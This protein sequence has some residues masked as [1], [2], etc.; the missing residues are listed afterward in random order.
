MRQPTILIVDD[1]PSARETLRIHLQ[2][3]PYTLLFA[4]SAAQAIRIAAE[5]EIDT[6]LLDVMMPD[7]TGYDLCRIWRQQERIRHTPI[8]LIT[9]L[10]GK[11]HVVHGLDAGADDFLTK[12]FNGLELRARVR[13]MLRIKR[14]YDEMKS[15][16]RMREEVAMM[17]VHDMRSPL[18]AIQSHCAILRRTVPLP[19][20]DRSNEVIRAQTERLK[21]FMNEL[22]LIAKMEHDHFAIQRVPCDVQKIVASVVNT[23]ALIAADSGVDVVLQPSGDPSLVEVDPALF[24]RMIENLVSNAVKFS[25]RGSVV[26]VRVATSDESLLVEVEDNGRGIPAADRDRVFEKFATA[27]ERRTQQI[28][29]GLAFCRAV[30]EA[31]GGQISISD[32]A[33]RG[34]IFSVA[35][36]TPA[37]IRGSLLAS[38]SS[39]SPSA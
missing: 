5:Q 29:L 28:G 36:Q 14:Q 27:G 11:Q 10:D 37:S 25:P 20:V 30:V 15:L 2:Q 39:P 6:I 16:L 12:P 3:E 9:A 17:L 13:T 4:A 35:L 24:E 22:L 33:P 19:E 18:M 26:R 32:A 8:L 7:M 34:T 1:T 38:T 31:H 21:S 23:Y